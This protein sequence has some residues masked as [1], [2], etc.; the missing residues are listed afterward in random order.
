MKRQKL[1]SHLG[2]FRSLSEQEFSDA[3]ARALRRFRNAPAPAQARTVAV[4][5]L[6]SR[7]RI[8]FRFAVAAALMLTVAIGVYAFRA[9]RASS[10]KVV[11]PPTQDSAPSVKAAAETPQVALT[12][13]ESP[14]PGA[15]PSRTE[16]LAAQI[17][18][19]QATDAG[20]T[21]LKFDAASIKPNNSGSRASNLSLQGRRL[22]GR[23]VTLRM[24][25]LRAYK[26][27]DHQLA[28]GPSWLNTDR[29]DVE[30]I[31]AD[32]LNRDEINGPVLQRLLEERFMLSVRRE[33]QERPIYVLTLA[34]DG[35]KL[36]AENCI[37]RESSAQA[38]GRP[39]GCGYSVMDNG[40]ILATQVNM[41]Q[42]ISLLIPWVMRTIVDKTAFTGFFDVDLKWNPNEMAGAAPA[43]RSSSFADRPS[44]FIALQE[45]L[46][47]KLEPA[48]GPVEV[49][50][51]DRAEKPTQ[52]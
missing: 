42:F 27:E 21:G 26:V 30:A 52:N 24:L 9:Q 20:P 5:E 25:I 13:P 19:A 28:G 35:A 36:K 46:G 15:A 2:L 41:T 50:V 37:A 40:I 3:E 43:D 4:E 32:D 1:D 51:I 12:T 16:I 45:K 18:A 23:N 38:D 6:R 17:A 22:V 8:G 14:K 11:V 10:P 39:D 29:Y 48:R 49:L 7:P 33:T 47:L 34:K 31:A 44:I